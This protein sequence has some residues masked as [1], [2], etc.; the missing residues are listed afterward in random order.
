MHTF[1]LFDI[2]EKNNIDII[3]TSLPKTSCI[4]MPYGND[5][6]CIGIDPDQITSLADERVKLA[7][8][9][10]HCVSGS[11]YNQHS[12]LDLRSKHEYRADKYGIKKLIPLDDL[13]FIMRKG[14]EAV[15]EIAEY[16]IVTE[17]F[18]RKAL[19][20]YENDLL[21]DKNKNDEFIGFI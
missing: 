3:Y 16:F 6:Y 15:W 5:E 12:P 4:S 10:G 17:E 20:I 14:Y 2:A 9:I 11:F 19:K 21:E 13:I 7:H 8:D 1:E 18:V